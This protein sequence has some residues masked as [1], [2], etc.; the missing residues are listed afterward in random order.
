MINLNTVSAKAED[1]CINMD[2]I[3]RK[4]NA[5]NDASVQALIL[6]SYNDLCSVA[7]PR[8]VYLYSPIKIE[9][10][11]VD[12]GYM[13]FESSNLAVNLE[14]CAQAYVFAATLGVEGDRMIEK[15]SRVMQAKALVCDTVA[16]YMIEGFCDY[17]NALLTQNKQSK[18]RFSPGYGDLSLLSQEKI[19]SCLDAT[20]KI[21]VALTDSFMMVPTKSVSA[22]IGVKN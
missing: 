12:F 14:G 22:I 21:G 5:E 1:V 20:K 10:N 4:L 2:A 16:S 8:A 18:P 11:T 9:A 13:S 3:I 7:N 15:Y 17:I 6:E 19:L